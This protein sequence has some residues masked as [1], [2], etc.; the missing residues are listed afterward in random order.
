VY[1]I[2]IQIY[3]YSVFMYAYIYICIYTHTHTH[4]LH[5]YISQIIRLPLRVLVHR[6][7]CK[8]IHVHVYIFIHIYTYTNI[9][10]YIYIYM[11]T[12]TYKHATSKHTVDKQVAAESTREWT[13][14]RPHTYIFRCVIVYPCFS[15]HIFVC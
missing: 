2:C 12:H 11:F 13:F 8:N 9:Y 10:I 7:L 4:T 1:Y 3:I 15:R 5:A 14:L 6:I